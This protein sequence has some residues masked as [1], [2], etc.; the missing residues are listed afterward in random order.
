MNKSNIVLCLSV[1][2]L[3]LSVFAITKPVTVQRIVERLG[4]TAGP[5]HTELQEFEG[6]VING[7]TLS[8]STVATTQTITA[9]ELGSNGALYDTVLFTPNTADVTLTLPATST[10]KAFLPLAGDTS[11]QCWYNA[12]TTTSEIGDIIFVAGTGWDLE[13][14]AT[15]TTNGSTTEVLEISPGDSAC[16][17]LTRLPATATTFNISA[18]MLNGIDAD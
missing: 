15:S 2:A 5:L 11:V 14:I 1:V 17:K 16:F 9:S 3:I 12:T 4:G 18:L 8:T 7:Y 10:L 6:G 13:R